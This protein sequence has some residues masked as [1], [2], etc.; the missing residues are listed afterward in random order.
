[1]DSVPNVR[2]TVSFVAV[3]PSVEQGRDW[4]TMRPLGKILVVH[5]DKGSSK[6]TVLNI[7]LI[8]TKKEHTSAMLSSQI[9]F[10]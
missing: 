7:Q 10:E 3:C 4:Q 5:F 6:D 9:S 8:I 2:E 1:M